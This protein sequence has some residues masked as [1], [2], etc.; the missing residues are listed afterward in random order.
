MNA[1]ETVLL[2]KFY[3]KSRGINEIDLTVAEVDFF[4]IIGLNGAG[5]STA[6]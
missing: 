5:K 3:G 6:I 1:V 4:G 2:T